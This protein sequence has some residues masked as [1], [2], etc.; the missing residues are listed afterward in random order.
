VKELSWDRDTVATAKIDVAGKV[1]DVLL[2]LPIRMDFR[3]VAQE[4]VAPG[5]TL[6]FQAVPSRHSATDLRVQTLTIGKR[7]AEMR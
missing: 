5:A 3:G 1:Y 2:G 7:T 6:T 4:D